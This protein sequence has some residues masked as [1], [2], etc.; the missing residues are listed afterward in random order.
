MT[1]EI[2]KDI[3]SNRWEIAQKSEEEFWKNYDT[4]SFLKELKK[5]Y[6]E[7]AEFLLKQWEKVIPLSKKTKILEV[8]CGPQ[9]V[10]NFLPIGEKYSI[11]PLADFYKERFN[12]DYRLSR[13]QNGI[14]EDLPYKNESFDVVILMNILDHSKNPEKVFS[15][16]QRVLKPEGILYFENYF[17]QKGFIYLSKI[18][19]KFKEFFV[20]EIFNIHHPYMFTKKDFKFLLSRDF[21]SLYEITGKD[22]GENENFSELKKKRKKSKKLTEKIPALF[23]LY[24]IINYISICKKKI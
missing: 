16:I 24:G 10:I 8:G 4:E 1:Q 15:E 3:P 21:L 23:G 20:K 5:M 11:D 2:I 22:P 18:F 7:K 19:G 12:F 17:Y 14:G 9:G 6:V 13:L